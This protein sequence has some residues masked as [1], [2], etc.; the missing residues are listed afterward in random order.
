MVDYIHTLGAQAHRRKFLS[1]PRSQPLVFDYFQCRGSESN[2]LECGR[3][4]GRICQHNHDV[5]IT[6]S[7]SVLIIA[8]WLTYCIA[9]E[10]SEV[11]AVQCIN[12]S[13]CVSELQLCDGVA[14]C[15]NG[16]DESINCGTG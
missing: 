2:L 9:S 15:H 8:D 1:A 4:I 6:C 12:E 10:C 16:T 5:S 3:G 7:K 13:K 14:D 11:N